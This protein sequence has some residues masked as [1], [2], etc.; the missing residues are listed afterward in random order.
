M[1]WRTK[2][3]VPLGRHGSF[4]VYLQYEELTVENQRRQIKNLYRLGQDQSDTQK[5]CPSGVVGSLETGSVG[6][7]F[8]LSID[9]P[10]KSIIH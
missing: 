9:I 1:R 5:T 8:V 10:I 3:H 6:I 4:F 7:V 2:T